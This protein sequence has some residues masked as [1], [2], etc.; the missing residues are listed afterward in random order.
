LI[1]FNIAQGITWL[2]TINSKHYFIR[3][4]V[5]PHVAAVYDRRK[6]VIL[7]IKP[8][9]VLEGTVTLLPNHAFPCHGER[10]SK[11]PTTDSLLLALTII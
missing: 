4:K 2:F 1:N 11:Y 7:T 5:E 8:L 9:T 10:L 6:Q 3:E